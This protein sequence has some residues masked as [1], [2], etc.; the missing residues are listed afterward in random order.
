V[1]LTTHTSTADVK[2]RVELF[3]YSFLGL[4]GLLYGDLYL[5]FTYSGIKWTSGVMWREGKDGAVHFEDLNRE[6][7]NKLCIKL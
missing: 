1:A 4:H 3:L 6:G 5:S 2:E 7:M